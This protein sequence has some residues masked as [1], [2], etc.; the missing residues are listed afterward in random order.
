MLWA[1]LKVLRREKPSDEPNAWR[2]LLTHYAGISQPRYREA[3]SR[4]L[5]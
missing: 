3:R 1:P 2:S 5:S 4:R